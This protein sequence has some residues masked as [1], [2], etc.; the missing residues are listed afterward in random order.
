MLMEKRTQKRI[1]PQMLSDLF[2]YLALPLLGG[3]SSLK[4][5]SSSPFLSEETTGDP[6]R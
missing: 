6:E 5:F 2:I 4:H 1:L 3:Y